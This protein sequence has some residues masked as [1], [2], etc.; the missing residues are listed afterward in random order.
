MTRR[1]PA[2]IETPRKIGPFR[3]RE[4]GTIVASTK[5]DMSQRP[6][7]SIAT[8]LSLPDDSTVVALVRRV[9][10][11]GVLL[12]ALTILASIALATP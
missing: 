11:A 2:R 3:A 1:P 4:P 6:D 10:F 8:V 12:A 9:V 7:R 5:R